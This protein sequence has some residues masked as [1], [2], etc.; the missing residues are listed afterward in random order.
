MANTAA[1]MIRELEKARHSL[2][3]QV[4]NAL[5][6]EGETILERSKDEFVPIDLGP[7]HDSADITV[8]EDGTIDGLQVVLS[9]GNE[10]TVAYA[11]AV[12]EHPSGYSPPSWEGK[13][14]HFQRGGNY[15]VKYL[16][17]PL[18]EAE[19]GMAERIG[20]KVKFG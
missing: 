3:T 16:E 10:K 5:V 17:R 20:Q 6:E 11:L 8:V 2:Y 7:L 1:S 14:I 9:Y 13:E 19:K 12:H 15:G 18:L 4:R